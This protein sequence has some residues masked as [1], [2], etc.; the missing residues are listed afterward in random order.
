MNK[1]FIEAVQ[2]LENIVKMQWDNFDWLDAGHSIYDAYDYD[3]EESD[4]LMFGIAGIE[5]PAWA[6]YLNGY[7]LDEVARA[8]FEN[9]YIDAAQLAAIIDN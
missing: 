3:E 4:G 1:E 6:D 9:G 5:M 2:K 7:P 8:A